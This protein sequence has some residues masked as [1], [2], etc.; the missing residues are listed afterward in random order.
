M[1]AVWPARHPATTSQPRSLLSIATLNSV[2]SRVPDG[3]RQLL[4]FAPIMRLPKIST[5]A[6]AIRCHPVPILAGLHHRYVWI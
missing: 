2:K 4:W 3:R 5:V 1:K 6:S